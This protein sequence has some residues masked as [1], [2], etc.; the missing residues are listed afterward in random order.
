M[1]KQSPVH[2][3]TVAEETY[4]ETIDALIKKHGYTK[5]SVIAKTLNIKPSSVTE[6]LKKLSLQGFIIHEPYRLVSL[7]AKGQ[8]LAAFLK[9]QQLSLQR[10][11]VSLD[12]DEHTAKQDACKMEHI[13]HEVILKRL[14]QYLD[15]IENT[16]HSNNCFTCFRH[17]LKNIKQQ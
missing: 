10:F 12:I 4:I 7:T 16:F 5:V 14:S 15:F 1:T 11:F 8:D 13:L 9:K 17:Y 2:R 3:L 6:M